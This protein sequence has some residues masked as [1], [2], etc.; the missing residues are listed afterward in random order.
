MLPIF[1][2][3]LLCA[4]CGEPP[5]PPKDNTAMTTVPSAPPPSQLSNAKTTQGLRRDF[6]GLDSKT[7]GELPVRKPPAVYGDNSTS[8]TF[9][10]NTTNRSAT[11][12][13]H[14]NNR[15]HRE[16][17]KY[18]TQVGRTGHNLLPQSES[19]GAPRF[20]VPLSSIPIIRTVVRPSKYYSIDPKVVVDGYFYRFKVKCGHGDFEV[21]SVRKLVKLL[22]EIEVIE[23]FK[24]QEKDSPA[25][26][27][28]SQAMSGIGRGATGL[29]RHPGQSVKRVGAGTGRAARAIGGFFS[30]PFR[31][32]KPVLD[33]DGTDR[34]L[35][36]KGAAGGERRLLAWELGIDVYTDNKQAQ[37]LLSQVARKR[38]M[39][40]LPLNAAVFA[41][42]GGAVFT[43]SLTPMGV[44]PT[45]EEIIRDK[46]PAEMKRFLAEDYLKLFNLHYG[47]R[48]DPLTALLDNPNYTPRE[49]AYLLRYLKD[50]QGVSG[51]REAVAFL[52]KVKTPG[53]AGVVSAQIELLSLLHTRARRMV[54]FVPVRNT[55]GARAKDGTLCLVI[56]VDTVR[57][58][59]DVA[60]SLK[61]SIAAAKQFGAR[62][63]EIWSTGD[64][65]RR[66]VQLA[67]RDGVTVHQN[68]LNNPLFRHPRRMVAQAR[69]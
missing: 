37:F 32:K 51:V 47:K 39:G 2:G 31:K 40:K 6:F 45:T 1:V 61:A 17:D 18:R 57:Y 21:V 59:D 42:P 41:L 43:L 56:S 64:I 20:T 34:S 11:E 16:G 12:T 55:L 28:F 50:M 5:E 49:Q 36:G 15:Q 29:V 13:S 14:N 33:S 35:L 27:G 3:I 10:R 4:G 65:D 23:K 8:D 54:Q 30:S 63:I 38:L 62:R 46:G 19:K 66:S 52:S 7:D 48:G 25:L 24:E 53:H 44:D 58:W 67:N 68:I 9:R 22:R 69:Q 60:K 26:Q